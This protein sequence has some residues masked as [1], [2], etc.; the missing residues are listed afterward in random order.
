MLIQDMIEILG[1]FGVFGL[2]NWFVRPYGLQTQALIGNVILAI[3]VIRVAVL[4]RMG[5]LALG[6][7][8]CMIQGGARDTAFDG[9]IAMEIAWYL[10]ILPYEK[11]QEMVWHHVLTILTA[12]VAYAMNV[13]CF[14]FLMFTTMIWSNI[15]LA[16]ARILHQRENEYAKHVFG[17]FAVAFFMLRIVVMPV[18]VYPLLLARPVRE[19][20]VHERDVGVLYYASCTGVGLIVGLQFFWLGKIFRMCVRLF[21]DKMGV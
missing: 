6:D 2:L 5:G 12:G 19:Y 17:M 13:T 7:G 1:L 14:T 20:W 21:T 9:H 3:N 8:T 4:K 11:T 16:S 10:A 15:L 18:F